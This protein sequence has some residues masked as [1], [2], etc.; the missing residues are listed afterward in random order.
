MVFGP[1][2]ES[3]WDVP[4]AQVADLDSTRGAR[5][6]YEDH[7]SRQRSYLAPADLPSGDRT[8]EQTHN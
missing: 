8:T 2:S 3:W 6:E 1:D 5:V 7:K 4:V